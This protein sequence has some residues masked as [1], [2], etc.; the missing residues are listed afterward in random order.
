[1]STTS[2]IWLASLEELSILK[3][4]MGWKMVWVLI[5]LEHT[6]L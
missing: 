4:G 5:P 3:M 1:M 6:K 2:D